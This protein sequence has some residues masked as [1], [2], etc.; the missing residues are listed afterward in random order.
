M[1]DFMTRLNR[2]RREAEARQPMIDVATNPW[3]PG[4]INWTDQMK[5][6]LRN[7][8]LAAELR[9]QAGVA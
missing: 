5:I 4:H 6:E 3:L 7:P 9:R 2:E 1:T 8:E